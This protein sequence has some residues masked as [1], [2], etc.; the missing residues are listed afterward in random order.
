MINEN[1]IQPDESPLMTSRNLK[2]K[3][4]KKELP[5]V[6]PCAARWPKWVQG[7]VWEFRGVEHLGI[8]V[9]LIDTNSRQS[10]NCR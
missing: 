9:S 7:F 1:L 2:K 3:T 4:H 8:I 6:H 10:T 5:L